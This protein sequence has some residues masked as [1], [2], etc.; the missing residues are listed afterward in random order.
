MSERAF[1]K[2]LGKM[3]LRRKTMGVMR[4]CLNIRSEDK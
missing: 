3:G 2:T 4:Y 1:C